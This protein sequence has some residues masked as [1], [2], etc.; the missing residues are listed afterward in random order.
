MALDVGVANREA[1]ERMCRARP[2]WTA[3]RPARE[4]LGLTGRVLLHA[5]PPIPWERM[6]WPM[7]GA[8]KAAILY[9]GWATAPADAEAVAAS[10]EVSFSPCDS[11]GAVGPMA[12]VI[13]PRMPVLV[14]EDPVNGTS[15]CSF[16]ADGPWGYQ[17]RFGA[18]GPE[19]LAGLAW[20]RDVVAPALQAV[21]EREGPID[22][23]T[24]M[25]QALTM[26]DE[27]HMR[28]AAATGLLARRLAA[29]LVGVVADRAHLEAIMRFLTRDNDQFFLTWAMCAAK[30]AARS[31]EGL[32]GCT[33][34][35]AMAR[36]GVEF[37]IRVAGLGDRWFTAP[38]PAVD[39]VYFP[40]FTAEDANPDTGDS[41]IMETYG[42]G[43]MAMAASPAV[44]KIVGARSF[45]DAVRTTRRMSEICVGA[46]PLFPLAPLEGEG[47]PT[48]IDIR[49]VVETGVVPA[50]NTAIAHRAAPRMIG[51]GI[52]TPP[53]EPFISALVAFG[54]A[55][56]A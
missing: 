25:S 28:N 27:M 16:F 50:I 47:T 12:G 20:I 51:A 5:G 21:L 36:N 13:S 41:A 3:V 55:Y 1:L 34:V 35:S 2:R 44:Q 52:S 30:A 31:I 33:V 19:T 22:L 7:C 15:A 37:G 39:G 42:L 32:D 49:K 38:A 48:G 17:L 24:L 29:P 53:L 26:G 46:N 56:G 18:Y 45:G 14:V 9:E 8:V 43:G 10:G 11:R 23:T 40:G 54:Q 4:A 6:C